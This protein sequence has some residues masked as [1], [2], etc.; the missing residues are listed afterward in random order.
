MHQYGQSRNL[1]RAGLAGTA[2]GLAGAT[3]APAS[4]VAAQVEGPSSVLAEIYQLQSAFHRAK[5]TQDIDLMMSLWPEGSR[6]NTVGDPNAPYVGSEVLRTFWLNSGSWMSPR[7]SL[8]PSFKIQID[9][10][11]A[12]EAWSYS[13]CHDVTDF[14]KSTRSIIADL[15]LAGTVKNI[16][17]KWL[18]WDMTSGSGAV[19]S[20]DRFYF[21][22]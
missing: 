18:F 8:V 5:S 7:F 21:S 1:L 12:D 4:L 19:L 3:L 2:V 20:P 11:T 14:D 13:E 22:A 10:K 6:I 17:N 16:D 9:V 15:F